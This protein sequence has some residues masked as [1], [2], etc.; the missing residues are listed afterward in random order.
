[1]VEP[2]YFWKEKLCRQSVLACSDHLYTDGNSFVNA[3]TGGR[4]VGGD[5]RPQVQQSD[6]HQE[7]DAPAESKGR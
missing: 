7:A 2:N 3:E 6:L 4:L 5:W 1:M